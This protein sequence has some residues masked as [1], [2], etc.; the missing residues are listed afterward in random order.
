MFE[1][2]MLRCL[3]QRGRREQ[4]TR[5]KV[6]NVELQ[7]LYSTTSTGSSKKNGS[8]SRRN[9]FYEKSAM[10]IVFILTR[11][12][13]HAVFILPLED[14]N[15]NTVYSTANILAMLSFLSRSL[16]QFQSDSHCTQVYFSDFL[17]Q[18]RFLNKSH[19][20]KKEEW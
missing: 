17:S 2:S 14:L 11:S 6:H 15:I 4:E 5:E 19:S 16:K 8:A 9:S 20:K 3:S 13:T 1:N 18:M 7:D 10:E 12:A